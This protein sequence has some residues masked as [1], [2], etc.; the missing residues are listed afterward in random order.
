MLSVGH[1]TMSCKQAVFKLFCAVVMSVTMG[2]ATVHGAE[3][4]ATAQVHE[5]VAETIAWRSDLST[6]KEEAIATGRPLLI[7]Y[8][9][10]SCGWC[11]AMEKYTHTNP[12][13]I[14]ILNNKFVPVR[15][16]GDPEKLRKPNGLSGTPAT[17]IVDAPSMTTLTRFGGFVRPN[18]YVQKVNVAFFHVE[19]FEKSPQAMALLNQAA[20]A[21]DKKQIAEA[22]ELATQGLAL[23]ADSADLLALRGGCYYLLGDGVNAIADL[24]HAIQARGDQSDLFLQRGMARYLNGQYAR[25]DEDFV[26]ALKLPAIFSSYIRVQRWFALNANGQQKEAQKAM[27]QYFKEYK[28]NGEDWWFNAMVQFL[29][30]RLSEEKITGYAKNGYKKMQLGRTLAMKAKLTGDSAGARAY[31]TKVKNI[32][33]LESYDHPLIMHELEALGEANAAE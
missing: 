1:S 23:C 25:A 11:R 7:E 30:G 31:L 22:I 2:A 18:R 9:S 3:E 27:H 26:T 4:A 20:V 17:L 5:A 12:D 6:A 28:Y 10:K 32:A 14:A 33:K 16:S 19:L 29:T 21:R 24:D 8:T 15:V 13:V